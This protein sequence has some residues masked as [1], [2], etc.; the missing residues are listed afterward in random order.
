MRGNFLIGI[1]LGAL[2]GVVLTENSGQIKQAMKKGKK[3]I[4]QK[5]GQQGQA[6]N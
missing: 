2:A 5:M 6:Q 4:Q 1:G 3:M